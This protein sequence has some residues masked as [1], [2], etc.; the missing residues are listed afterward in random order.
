V[1]G[2][3][4]LATDDITTAPVGVIAVTAVPLFLCP[5]V[6]RQAPTHLCCSLFEQSLCQRIRRKEA[7]TVG[8]PRSL[9]SVLT[10]FDGEPFKHLTDHLSQ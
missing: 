8:A 9:V 10:R 4:L 6:Y 1:R 5:Y 7:A 3:G 2:T